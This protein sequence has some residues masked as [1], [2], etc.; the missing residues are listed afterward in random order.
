MK[1]STIILAGLLIA[2]PSFVIASSK[3]T[4]FDV[5]SHTVDNHISGG[6]VEITSLTKVEALEGGDI[7]S[8]SSFFFPAKPE[9]IAQ[10]LS[11]PD[12]ICKMAAFCKGVAN[13]GKTADGQGWTGEMTINAQK[14]SKVAGKGDW[15]RDLKTATA[16][17]GEYKINFELRTTQE[18]GATLIN[19]K[20]LNGRV[21]SK[22]DI[23][24]RVVQGGPASTM[25]VVQTRSNSKM[26]PTVADRVALAK[27]I[28]R[29]G[30]AILDKSMAN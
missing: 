16:Q 2:A 12:G 29:D 11:T 5:S 7:L 18:Q 24:I 3:T 23:N 20:L 25:V 8:E 1:K 30:A 21:L 17:N 19:F 10:A 13:T 4:D 26:A 27:S 22:C 14:I 6:K 15:V 9:T 28:I